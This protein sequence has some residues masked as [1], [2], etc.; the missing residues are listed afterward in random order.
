VVIGGVCLSGG[1]HGT[2][3]LIGEDGQGDQGHDAY[4]VY[5]KQRQLTCNV[6]YILHM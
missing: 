1:H 4:S 6:P 5:R 3:A 2:V